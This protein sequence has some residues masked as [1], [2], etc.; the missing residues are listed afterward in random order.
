MMVMLGNGFGAITV[1]LRQL[2][3]N[4]VIKAV[5]AAAV[6][7]FIGEFR[8][9]LLIAPVGAQ[10]K[11]VLNCAGIK[12]AADIPCIGGGFTLISIK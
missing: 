1:A 2:A 9:P 8:L 4:R 3:C 5:N 10:Q 11:I 12:F 7:I 6:G